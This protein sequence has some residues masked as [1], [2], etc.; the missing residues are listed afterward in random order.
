MNVQNLYFCV[1]FTLSTHNGQVNMLAK[2]NAVYV[3][4]CRRHHLQLESFFVPEKKIKVNH[5]LTEEKQINKTKMCF[6]TNRS[7]Y[8]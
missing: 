7:D 4:V 8:K 2:R 1:F 5:R 3:R 6:G